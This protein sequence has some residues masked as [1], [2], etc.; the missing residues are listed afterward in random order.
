MWILNRIELSAGHD[1][2]SLESSLWMF[3]NLLC[4]QAAQREIVDHDLLFPPMNA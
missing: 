1:H 3:H 4:T 2:L